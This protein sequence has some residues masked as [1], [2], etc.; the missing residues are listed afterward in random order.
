MTTAK[1]V[2]WQDEGWWLGYWQEYPE[3][4]TQGESHDDLI[5]HLKDLYEIITSGDLPNVTR[6]PNPQTG[7]LVLA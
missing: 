2:Y 7:E 3:H 4:W 1:Y 6:A 5:V